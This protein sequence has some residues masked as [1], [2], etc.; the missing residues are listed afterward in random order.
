V[1]KK[2]VISP[3]LHALASELKDLQAKARALGL[4]DNTRELV[5]CPKCGL[6]E[7]VT[8]EGLLITTKPDYHGLDTGLRFAEKPAGTFRCPVCKTKFA[9]D[10]EGSV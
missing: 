6:E 2:T 4:F 3:E 1:K 5:R 8:C 9:G 7:D 10:D